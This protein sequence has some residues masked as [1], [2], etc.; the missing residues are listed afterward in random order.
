MKLKQI[1]QFKAYLAKINNFN[2]LLI[3]QQGGR[4]G[5]DIPAMKRALQTAIKNDGVN[6]VYKFIQKNNSKLLINEN[7]KN[8]V[9]FNKI[10]NNKDSKIYKTLKTTN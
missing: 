1:S 9:D 8:P 7:I 10:I 4:A 5:V 3:I 6:N 2:E